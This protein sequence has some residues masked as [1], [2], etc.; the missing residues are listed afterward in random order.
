[1]NPEFLSELRETTDTSIYKSQQLKCRQFRVD[2]KC[3]GLSGLRN[4][5]QRL[6]EMDRKTKLSHFNH[7]HMLYDKIFIL[8]KHN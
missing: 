6:K 8:F 4:Q 2:V 7:E 3:G 5:G 1:G